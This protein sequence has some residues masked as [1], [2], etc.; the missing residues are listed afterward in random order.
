MY[1]KP[2]TPFGDSE[3]WEKMY[4][5]VNVHLLGLS[6]RSAGFCYN[7]L[8]ATIHDQVGR[9]QRGGARSPPIP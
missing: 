9:H 1:V 7:R 8:G 2:I 4:V 3:F 6:K 5:K